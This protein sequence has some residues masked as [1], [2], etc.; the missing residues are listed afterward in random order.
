MTSLL[1][2]STDAVPTVLTSAVPTPAARVRGR[3]AHGA[4]F[5][6]IAAV[7]LTVMAFST[8]PTPLYSLY[9]ARDGFATFLL[10]VIFAVY[11]VGVIASLYLAGHISDWLGRRR[12]ILIAVL[13]E[14]VAAVLFLVWPS[15]PGLLV[16][17]FISGVGVGALTATATAHLSELRAVSRPEEGGRF[18]STVSTFV[19]NGGLA[20]GP[21]IA[22]FIAQWIAGPLQVPYVLFIVLLALAA[23]ALSLVPE[24]VEKQEERRAYAPQRMSLPRESR[25]AFWSAAIAALSAFAIFGL[26]TSLAPSFLAGT[27]HETSHFVAGLATFSVFGAAA[28]AQLLTSRMSLVSQVRLA[29]TFMAVGLAALSAGALLANLPLFIVA[30][31]VAGAG[32]G[33]QF[34]S[35]VAVAASLALPPRRGEV[36]AALFLVAYIGLTVPVL[37]VGLALAFLPSAAVLVGFSVVVIVLAVGSSLAMARRNA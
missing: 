25:G 15:V 13:I 26:F 4:G 23:L 18:S 28:V 31:I 12:I 14:L 29:A 1:P 34:R 16:A 9:Q 36:M 27:L 24:T 37:L 2:P 32:V 5:W 33:V 6:I 11:A 30:G 35:S 19:N 21:L 8:I 3:R 17:R 7:F 20:L 10:T 22:G